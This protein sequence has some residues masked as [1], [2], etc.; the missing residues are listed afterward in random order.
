[1]TQQRL[2]GIARWPSSLSVLLTKFYPGDE[3]KKA[4]EGRGKWRYGP[5]DS[6]RQGF[7]GENGKKEPL[8]RPRRRWED[9]IQMDIQEIGREG[10]ALVDLA[11]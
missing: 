8:G 2:K 9:N 10:V 4:C 6:C 5:E 7:S 3:I 1:M 11:Q